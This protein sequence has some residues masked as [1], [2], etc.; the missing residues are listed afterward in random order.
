MRLKTMASAAVL[1][2]SGAALAQVAT[3][4]TEQKDG[5]NNAATA[6]NDMLMT[7]NSMAGPPDATGTGS[8]STANA[9]TPDGTPEAAASAPPKRR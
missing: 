5:G 1:G 9:A 6:G 3:A 2:L 4:P 7:D 8:P